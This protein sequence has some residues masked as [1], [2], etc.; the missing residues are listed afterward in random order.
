V[1]SR[2][3]LV[4]VTDFGL[5]RELEGTVGQTGKDS[6]VGNVKWS[7]IEGM[8]SFLAYLYLKYFYPFLALEG[9]YSQKCDTFSFGVLM[10]ELA[11]RGK[12]PWEGEYAQDVARHLVDDE[13]LPALKVCPHAWSL[14]MTLCCD[15]DPATRPSFRYIWTHLDAYWRLLHAEQLL[16]EKKKKKKEKEKD[17]KKKT[18][19]GNEQDKG[20][21]KGKEAEVGKKEVKKKKEGDKE[22]KTKLNGGKSGEKEADI[23]VRTE[24]KDKKDVKKDTKKVT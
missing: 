19:G 21:E 23:H 22:P 5:S 17:N 6:I 16:A 24:I 12:E 3:Y 4:R 9:K 2:I 8:K 14:L 7:C 1:N 11:T 15:K 20:K 10:R 18:G 13:K